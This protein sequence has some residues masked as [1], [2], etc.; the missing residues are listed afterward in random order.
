VEIGMNFRFTVALAL[1]FAVARPGKPGTLAALRETDFRLFFLA[2][3]L[4][5]PRRFSFHRYS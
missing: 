3:D 1:E 4:L 5:I 2:F